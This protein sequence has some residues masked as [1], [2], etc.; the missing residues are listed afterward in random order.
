MPSIGKSLSQLRKKGYEVKNVLDIIQNDNATKTLVYTSSFFQPY[1]ETFSENYHFI[2]PILRKPTQTFK[3]SDIP[4][5]FISLGTVDN[6]QAD[7]YKLCFEALK[8]TPYHV[9][10]AIGE[11]LDKAELGKIPKNFSVY[12]YVDQIAVLQ[13]TDVFLTHCGMNSVSEALYFGIPLLLYPQTPEQYAVAVRVANLNAGKLLE[14]LSPTALKTGIQ[15]LLS[16]TTFKTGALH[17]QDS[18]FK[19]G[20]ISEAVTFIERT[21]QAVKA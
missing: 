4:T 20:G 2:G 16:D 12:S 6:A 18:F 10:L 21:A 1:A 9:I 11:T 15:D 7:F 14:T 13:V 5:I 17:I 19:A 3:K 8:D